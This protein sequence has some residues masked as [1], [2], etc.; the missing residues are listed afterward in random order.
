MEQSNFNQTNNHLNGQSQNENLEKGFHF[1]H[2]SM[3]VIVKKTEKI[4]TAI[5]MVTD[6]VHESEPLRNKLRSLSLSLISD[7]RKVGRHSVEPLYMVIEEV[8]G[9][10]DE[11]LVLIQ[12]A[13]TVGLISEMNAKIIRTELEKVQ[14]EFENLYGTPRTDVATHPGYANVILTPEMFDVPSASESFLTVP[15]E[16]PV[17]S[18]K[19]QK[20]NS[21]VLYKNDFLNAKST[22]SVNKKLDMGIKI[23]RRNDVLNVVKAN[24]T[25]SIKD[26][27]F[28]L[29]DL[30]EKT[31]QR[32][33]F[34]LVQEGILIKEGEKRWSVY[35]VAK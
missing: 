6:F 21:N 35:R 25:A 12:L 8:R 34:A 29:K 18:Y 9:L 14:K 23:A 27:K 31:I 24:V 3:S 32:E 30:N 28:V 10:S 4:A 16:N 26:V 17:F 13:G 7:T 1:K 11:I 5:Y 33:L 20:D 2:N 19:G 15:R 22:V